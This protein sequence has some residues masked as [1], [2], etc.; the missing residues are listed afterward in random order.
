MNA[1]RDAVKM[2]QLRVMIL[3]SINRLNPGGVL[4]RTLYRSIIGFYENYSLSL[5][6]KDIWYLKKKGY[7]EY[8]DNKLGGTDIFEEKVIGLTAEGKEIADRT[9][10]D[11]AL[12]I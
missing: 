6:D 1:D 3:Q 7:V 4:V 11:D 8:V 2:K 9:Q 12:E 5:L 10:T